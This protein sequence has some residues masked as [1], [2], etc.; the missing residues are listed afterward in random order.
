MFLSFSCC[1]FP[2]LKTRLHK[3]ENVL[4]FSKE[5]DRFI[6]IPTVNLMYYKGRLK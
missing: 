6:L 5:P 1:D 4:F 2:D 3:K